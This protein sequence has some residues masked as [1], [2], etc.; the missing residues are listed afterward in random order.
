MNKINSKLIL[1][2]LNN[3]LLNSDIDTDSPALRAYQKF[4]DD[5]LEQLLELQKHCPLVCFYEADS[6][7]SSKLAQRFKESNLNFEKIII[8][9]P[10]QYLRT[11]LEET[12]N[13]SKNYSILA[14]I[15][16]TGDET[17]K[18][19]NFSRLRF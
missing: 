12:I 10:D 6:K 1:V 4:D 14:Y 2:D 5:G 18:N 11:K 7:I 16:E 15:D 17:W 19:L 3:V 13:L 8:A 9:N